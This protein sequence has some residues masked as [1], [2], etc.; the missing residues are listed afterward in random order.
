[1]VQGSNGSNTLTVTKEDASIAA[2]AGNPATMQVNTAGGKA[3]P[4]TLQGTVQQAADSSLGDMSKAA[5]TVTLVPAVA[6]AANITC[7]VTNT[8]GALSATCSNVPV[9]AYTVQ[10]SIGGNYYQGLAVNSVLA[11]YD[12]SLGFVSGSGSVSD[13]GVAADFSVSVKYMKDNTLSGSITYIEHRATGDVK[14]SS[15]SLTSMSLVGPTAIIYGKA[16]VNGAAGYTLQLNMTDNG[17]PGIRRDTFGLQLS[18]GTL[19]PPIS[20]APA[21]ITAGNIQTH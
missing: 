14:V 19:T 5:A 4:I 10:W 18:G 9:N 15:T 8:N 7:P 2:A 12:P 3:G 11:V 17:E 16:T 1:L 13:N 21:A 20:F 6:G